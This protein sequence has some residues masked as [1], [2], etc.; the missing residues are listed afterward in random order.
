MPEFGDCILP[1]RSR[2][3]EENGTKA[4]LPRHFLR[5]VE[6]VAE[7]FKKL[8]GGKLRSSLLHRVFKNQ[9][10]LTTFEGFPGTG[11]KQPHERR[12]DEDKE[13]GLVCAF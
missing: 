8:G 11:E 5:T 2:D 7:I 9:D 12:V 1:S 6:D 3:P 10:Q 13:F 4:K